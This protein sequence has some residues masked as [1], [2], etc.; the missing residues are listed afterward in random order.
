[1]AARATWS[2]AITF[3]GFPINVRAYSAVKSRSSDSFKTLA[4]TD[5]LPVRQQ[6]VDT[7]GDVVERADCAKGVEIAKGKFAELAPDAIEMIQSAERSVTLDVDRFAALESVPLHLATGTFRILPDSKVPGAD[8]PVGILWNGLRKTRRAL[9]TTWTPRAGSRDAI[10]VIYAVEDGL[11][12]NTLP[13]EV[14]LNELPAW[15][16]EHNEQAASLFEQFVATQ[17]STDDFDLGAFESTYKARRDAAVQAALNGEVIE[18]P[19]SA[20]PAKAAVPDLMAAMSAAVGDTPKKA[21]AK[22]KAKA[23]A[24]A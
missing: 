7:N 23:K 22:P 21:P 14:E 10:L 20:E 2:G 24:A 3:A 1:M 17:Y 8:G 12:A 9:V 19:A 13:Y 6:L 16:P 15:A 5:K 4:P 11:V 18:A